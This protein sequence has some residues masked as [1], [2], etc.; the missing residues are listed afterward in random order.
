MK[1]ET[2]DFSGSQSWI[3]VENGSFGFPG[4]GNSG[5]VRTPSWDVIDTVI[6]R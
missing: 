6:L 3:S 1:T 4:G 2:R 5:I